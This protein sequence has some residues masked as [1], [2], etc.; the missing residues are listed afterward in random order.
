MLIILVKGLV[1][2]HDRGTER[3]NIMKKSNV[4]LLLILLISFVAEFALP[5]ISVHAETKEIDLVRDAGLKISYKVKEEEASNQWKLRVERKAK[6]PL[7]YQ[8][9]K[10]RFTDEHG[11]QIVY[12]KTDSMIEI[13]DWLVEKEFSE[14][15]EDQLTIELPSSIKELYLYIQIDQQERNDESE[16]TTKIQKDILDREAPFVLKVNNEQTN[17]DPSKIP[18]RKESKKVSVNS[19]QFIGAKKASDQFETANGTSRMYSASYQNKETTYKHDAGTYPEFSWQPDSQSNVINHQGG[20]AGQDGWDGVQNW[21]VASDDYSKSYIKYG[22]SGSNANIQ[23]RKYAQ[24]TDKPDEFKIKLNVK[25]NTTYKPGVDIVFLLDNSQS[26]RSGVGLAAGEKLRKENANEALANIVNKLKKINV[27]SA[28]NIRIG[29]HIFSDYTKYQSWGGGARPGEIRTFNL[30]K[31]TTDWDKMVNEYTRADSSGVTFT[32]RGLQEARDIFDTSSNSERHK[33]LFV[34]TDGAPNR[35]WETNDN[36]VQNLDM[37]PDQR[38]FT[39]FIK[40]TKG[41]YNEG[42]SLNSNTEKMTTSITPP[43]RNLINSHMTTANSTA[44]DLKNAGIEIHTIAL[45][46]MVHSA[47]PSGSRDKQIRGLYKMSTKKANATNGPN[48]DVASDFNFYDVTKGDDLTKYFDTWYETI[49]RT[50]DKGTITDPLGDMVELV[51]EPQWRQVM[52]GNPKIATTEEPKITKVNDDRQINVTNI[53]LSQNQE[54]EVEYTVRLKTTDPSFVSGRWYPANGET[55]LEPTPERSTDKL[56]FG[57]PSVKYQKEDFVIPVEKIWTDKA[58]NEDNYWKLRPNKITAKLQKQNGS[59]WSDVQ[60]IDLN[61]ENNWKG[62]FSSVEGGS[63]NTYRVIEPSRTNGYK[64]P[65]LNQTSFT[66]ETIPDGG[67]KITNELL[68][69]DYQFRKFMGD[70]QTPFTGTDLPK[71]KITRTDGK[72]FA[73]YLTPDSSGKVSLTDLSIGDYTVEETSVPKGFEK[74]PNFTI[75][76]T[77]N[78]SNNPTSLVVK[79]NNS[80]DE[81]RVTNNLKDFSI[82]IEKVD[83]ND[84]LLTGAAFK[85]SG[86]NNYER[87]E[88]GG[89][90][91]NFTGLRPGQYS[92]IETDNPNGYERL[93]SPITFEIEQDGTVTVAAHSNV[94]GSG[95]ISDTGNLIQLKVS[96]KKSKAGVLPSTGGFGTQRSFLIA[97]SL[98][99]GGGLLSILL[100]YLNRRKK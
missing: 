33:L 88:T 39:N 17:N 78:N 92:L 38:Y 35:S 11:Q 58:K 55:F 87:T 96:N 42:K 27:P 62:E 86:P 59:S 73:E 95:R 29:L 8:R 80:T 99:M 54:I 98:G 71:F 67:I 53:N 77:E 6:E 75:N 15:I 9:L 25:G 12:P 82:N 84:E 3:E 30:S 5:I 94:S 79:V 68:K 14:K 72:V 50:V 2:V 85:L 31:N 69:S 61:A 63:E 74:M 20:V 49:I 23:I 10:L 1:N 26:M 100:L 21:N 57:R 46:L 51:D 37:Y 60:S 7:K 83:E 18:L 89:P 16:K 76:V 47:E 19:E 65:K 34:L 66:S 93:K 64:N 97:G 56:E 48:E 44:M 32:Q 41:N 70:G 28:E 91:F 40:G 45:Q 81:Y 90:I 4:I 24:Q 13:D 43:Y 36:G 52:N 22:D